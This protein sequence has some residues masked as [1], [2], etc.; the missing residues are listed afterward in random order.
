VAKVKYK[1]QY[2]DPFRAFGI[3]PVKERGWDLGKML[4]TKQRALLIKVGMNPDHMNYGQARQILNEQFR[5][6]K[7]KLCTLK[8]ANVLKRYGYETK[9]M[10]MK[11]ASALLD[12]LSKNGWR[13]VA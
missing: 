5:R 11:D 2:I 9:D 3:A 1:S 13:K 12:Q 6:W 8:Q 4:S 10:T 7:N